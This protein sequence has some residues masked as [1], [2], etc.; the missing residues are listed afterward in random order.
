MV[1]C[2]QRASAIRRAWGVS[3]IQILEFFDHIGHTRRIRDAHVLRCESAWP[4]AGAVSV[5][6]YSP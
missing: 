3:A 2:T 5:P 1:Q 6:N 4:G